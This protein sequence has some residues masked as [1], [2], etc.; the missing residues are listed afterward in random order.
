MK[1]LEDNIK[2]LLK[3]NHLAAAS[4]ELDAFSYPV[5]ARENG[6][7][8]EHMFLYSNQPITKKPRPYAWLAIDSETGQLLIVCRCAYKDFAA[9]LQI[10]PGQL[11][12]YA[13]PISCSHRE[14]RQKQRAFAAVYEQLR[15]FA[16][17]DTV[18]GSQRN[19]LQQYQELSEQLI[20]AELRPFYHALSPEFYRWI[21]SALQE[22]G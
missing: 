11:L 3:A 16:F 22:A 18:S 10:P 15:E 4:L 2:S 5:L 1:K 20:N 13:A 7:L 6:K 21:E 19:L 9:G 14:L 17:S 8:T 12:D